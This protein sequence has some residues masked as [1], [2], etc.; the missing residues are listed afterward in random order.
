MPKLSTNITTVTTQEVSLKPLLKRQLMQR[1]TQFAANHTQLAL[2][3][4]Q[5]EQAKE[6]I[7]A[8]FTK[9]GELNTLQAGVQV[10]G[11]SV[12]KHVGETTKR[13]DKVALCREAGVTMAQIDAAT[14]E[15]PKKHYV[16]VNVPGSRRLNDKERD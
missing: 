14:K 10:D 5:Q 7:E 2:L 8:L 13:L 4:A 16:K 15:T 12:K 11:F 6:E 3:E 1:L 9:A